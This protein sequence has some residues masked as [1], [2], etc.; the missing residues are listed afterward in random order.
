MN[1]STL[2]DTPIESPSLQKN[3]YKKGTYLAMIDALQ[4]MIVVLPAISRPA[5]S[6]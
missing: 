4:E 6:Q 5:A 1:P 2:K 3:G